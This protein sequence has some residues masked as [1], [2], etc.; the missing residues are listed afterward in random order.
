MTNKVKGQRLALEGITW[1]ECTKRYKGSRSSLPEI[2]LS[3]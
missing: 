2:P 3:G 1:V